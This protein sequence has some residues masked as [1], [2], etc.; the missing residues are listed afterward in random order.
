MGQ[1]LRHLRRSRGLTLAELGNRVGRA[2][3]ALSL[4]ENGRREPKLSVLEDLAAALSV[5]VE[6]LLRRQAPSHRAQLE[7]ALE[8]AQRDPT[9]TKL[10][11]P[12]LKVSARVPI[13]VL[14]HL[15]KL[16]D[17]LRAQHAK[18]TAT[19][20]EARA[21][22]AELR[23]A[24]RERGNYFEEIEQAAD[25]AL[26][27]AGYTGG[28]LSQG[29]LL[30]VVSHHG[31]SVRYV[32][33]LPQSV[34]SLTDLRNRRIYVKQEP[35]GTHS[36][37]TVLLQALGHFLLGHQSPR[38]FG[39]FLRQRVESNYFAAAV[40]VPE[41]AAVRFLADA[42]DAR[43]L[44]VEDL[45]D[46]FS[47]SYEMAA[48]RFTNLATRHLGMP[49]HFTKNDSS[50]I[51]YKAYECDGL[52]FP[53]DPAGAIEGQRM[54]RKWAGRQVFGAA[55]R[56]SPYCQYSA[57]PS[58]TYFC[59]SQ[60]DPRAD[61]GFAI[62]LGVPYEHSRWFR[63]RETPTRLRSACPDGECCKRPPAELAARWEGMAW[64]SARAHS[65][66][67]SALPAGSFPGVDEADVYEF[68]DRHA[69][70]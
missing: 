32:Q 53:A 34:R 20:E 51:I 35:V 33:D 59:V 48:H 47:V 1:R 61:R 39:D 65:H 3:S 5:P 41:R 38:D 46:V 6:E 68:L 29:M 28:A 4:L 9:Y 45:V 63:G 14:E 36:P 69:A 11:L 16:A 19:P 13:D 55:D 42:K 23:A 37:R 12:H 25:R 22:N 58:G 50:G 26:Q 52:V 66:V 7:I 40:L 62:T 56:F 64:P 70:N 27:A 24:M 10:G 17:E 54:C 2:P 67:L 30:S 21:A 15:V 57:T 31:F 60:V 44:A 18:P 49:C 43:D 8:E